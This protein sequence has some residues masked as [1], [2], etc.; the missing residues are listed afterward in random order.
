MLGAVARPGNIDL[1]AGDRLSVALLR[2]GVGAPTISDLSRVHLRRLNPTPFT[3][4]G[5]YQINVSEAAQ[6][7]D[8]RYDPILKDGRPGRMTCRGPASARRVSSLQ[9]SN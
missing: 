6:R 1:R 9:P 5:F 2:A 8:V 3:A 4:I 7:G